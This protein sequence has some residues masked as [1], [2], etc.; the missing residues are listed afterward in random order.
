MSDPGIALV[1]ELLSRMIG[2]DVG[3]IGPRAIRAAVSARKKQLGGPS[4]MEYVSLVTAK[5]E[6]LAALVEEVVVPETW[7]FRDRVPFEHL[8]IHARE[9]WRDGPIRVLSVPCSTG[10]E[11][12]SIAITLLDAG[13]A[14][15]D[16]AIDAMDVS[17]RALTNA[18][19]GIYGGASFRGDVG[20]WRARYFRARKEDDRWELR[21]EPREAVS[22]A[23]GNLLDPGAF[24]SGSRYHAIFCRNVLIYLT[25]DARAAAI[26]RLESM[27]APGGLFVV[28]HAEA[29]SSMDTRF[30]A[31]D[32][33]GAFTYMRVADHPRPVTPVKGMPA[34]KKPPDRSDRKSQPRMPPIRATTPPPV[35]PVAPVVIDR[36][37][38]AA[39]LANRG[40]LTGAAELCAQHLRVIGDDARAYSLLGTIRQASG[41]LDEA[42]QCFTRALY[43]DPAHYESLVQLALLR[44]RRGDRA[45]A[46]NFRRRAAD[47]HRKVKPRSTGKRSR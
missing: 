18:R 24:T 20:E 14:R 21:A 12:Y 16:F 30:R 33:S 17:S 32:K 5:P 3:S 23:R 15:K 47:A 35:A 34:E 19:R 41:A 27:L 10:E 7:F 42:E 4:T 46:A 43:C 36:L 26:A 8:A 2:L 29:L 13:F 28:G 22:F 37:A 39:Q 6:E 45:G 1:E 11:P 9:K 38:E 25:A 31:V 44:E 40:D